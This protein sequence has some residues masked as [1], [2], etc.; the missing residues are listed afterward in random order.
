MT[1]KERFLKACKGE[2]LE[3]PPIWIMRQAGRYLPEYR[4]LK[5]KHSFVELVRTP[6]LTTEVTL[7]PMK[8]FDLD[9]AIIF[10]DILIIPEA[11]GQPYRFKEE[12]GI[13]MEYTLDHPDKIRKLD[14]TNIREKLGYLAQ[15]LKMVKKALG[16]NHAL[17][18]FGGSPWTLATYMVEGG[19]SKHFS[20][21]KSLAYLEKAL[22][23][24]LMQKLSDALI[25]LFKMQIESGAD[26]IQIFDSWGNLCSSL[27]YWDLSL[28]WIQYIINALPQEIPVILFA[29][30]MAHH[31]ELLLKTNATVLSVDWTVNMEEMHKS[32]PNRY[33]F[34]GNMDPVLL[35]MTPEVVRKSALQILDQMTP[36]PGHI[37][38]L[39][40][41]ILP[42]AKIEN[43]ETLVQIV[44]N[45][46]N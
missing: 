30:G 21:I 43:V 17:L 13:E 35:N 7:Q 42:E 28:K 44:K 8:R 22:F 10:S 9:A 27:D 23:E 20:K 39:G 45:Y 5:E 12:G 31:G 25:E 29:K 24:E 26:A 37:F 33:R 3:R 15:G 6:D 34:Q 1:G 36:Y 2:A 4:Q 38:N 18:G 46:K 11:L 32:L 41:G 19:S 16:E 40:H 14:N